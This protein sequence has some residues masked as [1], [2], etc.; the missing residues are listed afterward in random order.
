MKRIE[1]MNCWKSFNLS[2]DFGSVRMV[3][4]SFF[5]MVCY[6]VIFT[7]IVSDVFGPIKLAYF[8]I[9]LFLC[10][11]FL[12]YPLHK[13]F[14]GVP[15]WLS[16]KKAK[17]AMDRTT[18]IPKLFCHIAGT[19]PK[20]LYI[21]SILFPFL[22]ITAVLILLTIYFPV[23]IH[24]YSAI[25]SINF[26]LSVTDLIYFAHLLSAPSHA[27]IEEDGDSCRILVRQYI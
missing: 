10:C 25:G 7:L 23:G 27:I 19:I 4:L 3:I 15:I 5:G 22:F 13:F 20:R 9:L 11:L 1:I 12:V 26:G 8:N 16:R 24:Y 6:F 18:L 14:H 17:L 2:K 21:I